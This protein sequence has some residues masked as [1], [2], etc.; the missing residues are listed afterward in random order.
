MRA[1]HCGRC[2]QAHVVDDANN[3]SRALLGE[4]KLQHNAHLD[5]SSCVVCH[6]FLRKPLM[7]PRIHGNQQL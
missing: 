7:H 2:E 1:P 6:V 3:V 4:R 5:K